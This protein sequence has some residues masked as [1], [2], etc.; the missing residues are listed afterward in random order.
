MTSLKKHW[1][2]ALL[3]L[4]TVISCT[5]TTLPSPHTSSYKPLPDYSAEYRQVLAVAEMYFGDI[6]LPLVPT[7]ETG[8]AAMRCVSDRR[9]FVLYDPTAFERI[10][11]EAGRGAVVGIFAHEVGHYL[12]HRSGADVGM[13]SHE[14]EYA[15]DRFAGCLMA[16]AGVEVEGFHDWLYKTK[17]GNTHPDG[18]DRATALMVAFARC[19]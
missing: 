10:A 3:T 13:S 2:L 6:D 15:A 14:Q 17:G 18:P 8:T 7:A 12:A 9:C 5:D 4:L 16:T 19:A 11:T 1:A